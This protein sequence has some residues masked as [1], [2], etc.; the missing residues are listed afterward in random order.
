MG[1]TD[2]PNILQKLDVVVFPHKLCN[3]FAPGTVPP[4]AYHLC[5]F[6]E[7]SSLHRRLW[8]PS[9]LPEG[10]RLEVGWCHLLRHGQLRYW[11][12]HPIRLHQRRSLPQMGCT[13]HWTVNCCNKLVLV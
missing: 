6:A 7:G 13:N 3:L 5:V 11:N 12:E 4:N 9:R 1:F 8:W 10:R 2:L